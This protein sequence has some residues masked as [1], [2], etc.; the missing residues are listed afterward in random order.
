MTLR[1]IGPSAYDSLTAGL[2]AVSSGDL[3]QA[4]EFRLLGPFEVASADAVLP[5][6]GP[7]QRAL[8]AYLLLHANEVVRRDALIDALWGDDPPARAQNALQVAI[9]GLRKLLGPDR[10][11]TV[12][13]GY[14]LR[15]EPGELDL[16]GFLERRAQAPAE[17]LELWRGAALTGVDA[18]F[19]SAEAARL[20]DLWLAAGP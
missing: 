9:H 6:G 13:D 20:E 10:I 4:L 14:R 3:R 15:V 8:L 5:V 1:T 7:R 18:P 17:A 12:A 16:A 2:S 11:D 19:A